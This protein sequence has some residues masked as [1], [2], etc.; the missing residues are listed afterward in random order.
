[1]IWTHIEWYGF[2]NKHTGLER[3]PFPNIYPGIFILHLLGIEVFDK[4]YRTE[5]IRKTEH[6]GLI[7]T[8]HESG[9]RD[10]EI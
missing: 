5:S 1:M 2:R 7:A 4:I 8:S 9:Q 3:Q 6:T 10:M